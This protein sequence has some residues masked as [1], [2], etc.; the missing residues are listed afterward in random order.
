MQNLFEELTAAF[1]R[2]YG[3]L[4]VESYDRIVQKHCSLFEDS[5]TVFILLQ[6]SGYP[7]VE[8]VDGYINRT[9]FTSYQEQRYCIIDIETNGSK[10]G[11]SQVIEIGAVMV[12]DG[13]VMDRLE[14]FVECA[15]LPEHITKITGIEPEDLIGA[16]TRK[17]A[18]I[19]LR[20]FMDDAIF[21]AHNASFDHSFLNASF[22]RFGLGHIGNPKLCTIDLARR[23]FKSDRYG[24][25]Y[26]NEFLGIEN[27]TH[28]R[29]YS[30]A[31]SATKVMFKSF[32]TVPEYINTTDDLLRFSV[33]SMKARNAKTRSGQK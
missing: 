11:S 29:A 7:I 20:N 33:S 16:P 2:N 26:L 23:S 3:R 17:Q 32:E 10:P 25:A 14:T 6:A 22:D 1:R 8:R 4:S 28:H 30:D 5:D 24:L 13:T 27:H 19:S 21:V 18:L 31:L 12:Q 15:Y 9:F